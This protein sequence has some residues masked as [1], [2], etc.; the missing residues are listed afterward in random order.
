M[1]TDNRSCNSNQ[2]IIFVEHFRNF[3]FERSPVTNKLVISLATD[4][5]NFVLRRYRQHD[6]YG[7]NW[8]DDEG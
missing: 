6:A 8:H 3:H 5:L 1:T 4:N 2:D 7:S